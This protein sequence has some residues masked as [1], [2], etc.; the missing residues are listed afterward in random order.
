[1]KLRTKLLFLESTIALI[2]LVTLILSVLSLINVSRIN[3]KYRNFLEEELRFR[4]LR[5]DMEELLYIPNPGSD[6]Y[7]QLVKSW[8]ALYLTRD[9]AFFTYLSGDD[10]SALLDELDQ[11]EK[12]WLEFYSRDVL[13]ESRSLFEGYMDAGKRNL[14]LYSYYQESST[15]ENRNA[16]DRLVDQTKEFLKLEKTYKD[17][18]DLLQQAMPKLRR[19]RILRV[20]LW[21]GVILALIG[22]ISRIYGRSI[23]DNISSIKYA[24]NQVSGGN[25]SHKLRIQSNDEFGRLARDFNTV[26]EA[27]WAKLE[28][29]Q[30]IL[31]DVG[32]SI[33]NEIEIE[34]VEKAIVYLSL[35]STDADGAALYLFDEEKKYLNLYY[36]VGDY[37]PPYFLGKER[38]R[39]SP[40]TSTD[41]LLSSFRDYPVPVGETI[42]GES[43]V[44]GESIFAKWTASSSFSRP[45]NH[46][47]YISSVMAIPI[48][49]GNVVLGVLCL[50]QNGEDKFF[51]DLEFANAQSFCELAAI[52]IDNLMKY[53]EMLDVFE[54]NREIDIASEIQQNLL[55]QQIPKLKNTQLSFETRTRRGING[56]FYD[57]FILDGER[58][59]IAISEVAGKGVPA[60]LVITM[61]KTI[62]KL[63]AT[64]RKNAAQIIEDLNRNITEKIR[65]ENIASLAIVIY[66]QNTGEISYASAGHQPMLVYS[67]REESFREY[68]PRG[69]PVGLEKDVDY[70]ESLLTLEDKDLLL[71]FTDGIPEALDRSGK[72]FTV[73]KL[74]DICLEHHEKET[75]AIIT[76]IIDELD[77]FHRNSEQWDDQTLFL[78]K[79]GGND[80]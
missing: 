79:R 31:G 7:D 74:K 45:T 66:N 80:Q 6:R 27:L 22:I 33:S 11:F 50:L 70:E 43:A 52:S 56:D 51:S 1:M 46:P 24:I 14:S 61:I 68:R 48:R 13:R 18:L 49:L 73:D 10:R 53:N 78:M 41:D 63:V 64:P 12:S 75:G 77:Y 72:A 19:R 26:T 58:T 60:A 23:M 47:Y 17:L 15:P 42:I 62:L 8:D 55:P 36:A 28:S 71:M 16:V 32:E 29:V 59:L 25:F 21:D 44:K 54:L 4:R 5:I 65:I 20:I 9:K 3:E 34:K 39:V 76:E 40:F 69:I 57:C 38:E 67:S 30:S 35:K 2:L 37:R